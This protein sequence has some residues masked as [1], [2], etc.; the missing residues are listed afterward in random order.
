MTTAQTTQVFCQELIS[1]GV[2]IPEDTIKVEI[3]CV[4]AFKPVSIVF[5]CANISTRLIKKSKCD[6]YKDNGAPLTTTELYDLLKDVVGLPSETCEYTITAEADKVV[7]VDIK[8]ALPHDSFSGL[9]GLVF[10]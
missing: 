8:A 1:L 3:A 10:K 9:K 6:I 2:K 5:H 4:E 7:M